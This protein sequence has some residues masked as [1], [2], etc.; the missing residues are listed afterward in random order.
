LQR[1]AGPLAA[2]LHDPIALWACSTGFQIVKVKSRHIPSV[3]DSPPAD[4]DFTNFSLPHHQCSRRPGLLGLSQTA[5]YCRK[6]VSDG[7][8]PVWFGLSCSGM[9]PLETKQGELE[10]KFAALRLP[11][12]HPV[13]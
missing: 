4:A 1:Q 3:P 13:S 8:S 6:A 10:L 2:K 5:T 11:D 7:R 12:H 9:L